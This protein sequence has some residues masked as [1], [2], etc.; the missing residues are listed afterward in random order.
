ME[1]LGEYQNG[2]V[3][4][5]IYD[6]GTKIRETEDDE[7]HP[8]FAENMDIKICN[9]CDGGCAM[10]FVGGTKVL[11]GDMSW[12]EIE[13]IVVGDIVVG[14]EETPSKNGAK[15]R[16]SKTRVIKTFC[17]VE[18]ELIHV[19]TE[20]GSV[21]CTPNHPFL[22]EGSG[23]T[24][25]RYFRKINDID[26]GQFLFKTG[27]P[28]ENINYE[29]I[30]YKLGY[31]VGSWIGDGSVTKRIDNHGYDMY[32]CRFVTKDEEINQKVF[33]L[34]SEMYP[35]FYLA[36]FRFSDGTSAQAV[37]NASKA[38]YEFMLTLF[39]NNLRKNNS[40]EYACGLISGMIDSEGHVDHERKIIKITNTNIEYINEVVRCLQILNIENVVED[41]KPEKKTHNKVYNVRIKGR[42]AFDKVLWYSRPVCE[43]KS[44]EYNLND[45]LQHWKSRITKKEIIIEKQYVYNLE[46]E[47]HTYIA[48]N[49]MVHNCHEGSTPNGKLGDI[50][51]EKFIDSMHPHTEC[52]IGGGNVFEHPDLIPF[53]EKLKEKQVIPNITV[54]QIHFKKNMGLLHDLVDHK[55][56]YGVG[57]SLNDPSP[58]F[59]SRIKEFP[60]AVVHTI[61]G[62]L[63]PWQMEKLIGNDLK[64]LILGYKNLRRGTTYLETHKA[65]IASNQA[66]LEHNLSQL[67]SG[68]KVLSFDNLAIEQLHVKEK[69]SPEKWEE[70][71][72][73]DDGTNTF[74]IDMVERKFARSSTAPLDKRY[75][76][77]DSVDE[78]FKVVRN[79]VLH[80]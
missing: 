55:L 59:I 56:V 52:S 76:L 24:S 60:N 48:N 44:M 6:D 58:E 50:L 30:N 34:T 26:V 62:V 40:V 35:D 72:A 10:C 14:F 16:I 54:N 67:L 38:A 13:D 33:K 46:T 71:Y 53:L 73:G 7:F 37:T 12:K 47:T 29:G 11:M 18:D 23:R 57:V 42:Y 74:Y 80:S 69:I 77:L 8:A 39:N 65:N 41:R 61:N 3:R 22:Y 20:T 51:S 36:N 25:A 43:R 28:E 68:V 2:N 9:R 79:E 17:H 63:T 27:I 31:V 75:D 66:F 78:M 70:F 5:T 19:T 21:I 45:Y 4:T 49:Y 64:V 15:R 1:L 32:K